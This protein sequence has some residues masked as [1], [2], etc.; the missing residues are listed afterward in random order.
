[1][2]REVIKNRLAELG[3]TQ[4]K[5]ADDNGFALQNFNSFLIGKRSFPLSDIEK[6]FKYL[7]L[8]IVGKPSKIE[9]RQRNNKRT[10]NGREH[11]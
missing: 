3:L 11:I 9:V 4:K 5:C 8:E 1:M 2:I 10:L 7:D 6:V